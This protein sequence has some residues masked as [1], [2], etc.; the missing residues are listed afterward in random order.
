MGNDKPTFM[1]RLFEVSKFTLLYSCVYDLGKNNV[2]KDS[3]TKL[4]ALRQETECLPY[5]QVDLTIKLYDKL[6]QPLK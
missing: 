1:F 6:G 5:G 4:K 3:C 2:Q